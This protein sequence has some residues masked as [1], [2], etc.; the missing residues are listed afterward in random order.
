ML[1]PTVAPR[2]IGARSRTD[3]GMRMRGLP[4]GCPR[5]RARRRSASRPTALSPMS[6]HRR[7]S[8]GRSR[9]SVWTVPSQWQNLSSRGEA[10]LSRSMYPQDYV[11][12]RRDAIDEQVAAFRAIATGGCC[13]EALDTFETYFFNDLVIVLESGF[14]HRG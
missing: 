13:P 10:V 4:V 8:P 7:T 11:D 5:Q 1:L 3:S 6:V 9:M 2:R 14:V 12:Q